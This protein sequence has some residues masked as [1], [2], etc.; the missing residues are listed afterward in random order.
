M[1]IKLQVFYDG[2]LFEADKKKFALPQG[3]VIYSFKFDGEI[4]CY[5]A[6]LIENAKNQKN[7]DVVRRAVAK[8]YCVPMHYIYFGS[9]GRKSKFKQAQY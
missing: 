3:W 9:K 7:R 4:F 1:E 6:M 2:E 5:C 8:K